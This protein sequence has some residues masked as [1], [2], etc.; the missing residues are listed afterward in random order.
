MKRKPNGKPLRLFR[1]GGLWH[2]RVGRFGGSFYVA[3]R[4]VMTYAETLNSY[5]P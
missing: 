5:Q 1:V 3:R 2:W 4:H